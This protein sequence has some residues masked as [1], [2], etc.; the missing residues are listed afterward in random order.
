MDFLKRW[1]KRW[2]KDTLEFSCSPKGNRKDI[3]YLQVLVNTE[4]NRLTINDLSDIE[5]ILT[6]FLPSGNLLSNQFKTDFLNYIKNNS[7]GNINSSILY[8]KGIVTKD[9]YWLSGYMDG[10][11]MFYFTIIT[12]NSVKGLNILL[13][14]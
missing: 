5:V 12:N 7:Y 10:Y 8:S 13:I 4:Y 9:N 1:V 14:K 3:E 6:L 11:S 2:N